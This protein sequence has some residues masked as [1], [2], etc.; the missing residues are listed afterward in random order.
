MLPVRLSISFIRSGLDSN[1]RVAAG[2]WVFIELVEI[3]FYSLSI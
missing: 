1:L 2:D 3:G